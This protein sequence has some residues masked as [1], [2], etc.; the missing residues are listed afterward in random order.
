MLSPLVSEQE[1][2]GGM[3]ESCCSVIC[4]QPLAFLFFFV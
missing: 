4:F 1:E 3:E 2:E